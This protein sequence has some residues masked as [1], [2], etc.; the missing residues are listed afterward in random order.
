MHFLRL[1]N[2]SLT[3]MEIY[4]PFMSEGSISLVGD[5][6]KPIPIK[7]VGD[8]DACQSIV[9]D[10]VLLFSEK[11]YLGTSVLLQVVECSFMNVPIHKIYFCCQRW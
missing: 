5:S 10:N 2:H 3:V 6:T 9:L 11:I 7:I 1:K 4:K 8:I